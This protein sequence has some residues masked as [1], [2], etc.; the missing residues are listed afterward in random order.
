MIS[1]VKYDIC[2]QIRRF[3]VD[4]F[5]IFGC[6]VLIIGRISTPNASQTVTST[7]LRTMGFR[8]H[9]RVFIRVLN[10]L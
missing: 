4:I 2:C 7:L 10:M 5:T 3:F 6:G 1:D 8:A 9:D